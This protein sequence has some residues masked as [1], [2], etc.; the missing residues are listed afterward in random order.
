MIG[1]Q[2]IHLK[3]PSG[4]AAIDAAVRAV[5]GRWPSA[6]FVVDNEQEVVPRPEQLDLDDGSEVVIY[7]DRAA[8]EKWRAGGYDPSL[9]GTMIYLIAQRDGLTVV[10]EE[11]PSTEMASVL[12]SIRDEVSRTFHPVRRS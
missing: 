12:S 3:V 8:C 4:A 1:G 6:V 7:K 5:A 11:E 10:L 2:D 9:K